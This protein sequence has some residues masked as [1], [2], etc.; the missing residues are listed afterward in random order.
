MRRKEDSFLKR[1]HS[2]QTLLA[3]EEPA[4]KVSFKNLAEFAGRLNQEHMG[5]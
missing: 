4:L 2:K 5:K 3:K 1:Y